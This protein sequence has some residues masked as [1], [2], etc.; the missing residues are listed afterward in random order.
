MYKIKLQVMSQ[1]SD[2]LLKFSFKIIIVP[3]INYL[4]IQIQ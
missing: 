1:Q 3:T 2:N 4:A